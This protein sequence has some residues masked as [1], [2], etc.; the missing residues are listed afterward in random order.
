MPPEVKESFATLI[1]LLDGVD[2]CIIGGAATALYLDDWTDV[3]DI[4]V[5]LPVSALVPLVDRAPIIDKSDGG[6]D[7]F[8]S[9]LYAGWELPL[10]IDFLAG[11]EVNEAG[12][13]RPVWPVT[14][15]AIAML[16]GM[17]YVP[18]LA[19]HIFITRQLGRPRDLARIARLQAAGIV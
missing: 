15:R 10:P 5:V 14:R 4:D 11:F 17:A 8:R 13:W 1:P 6:T 7:R 3:H 16:G 12:D 9:T 19:E 18:D 2:W